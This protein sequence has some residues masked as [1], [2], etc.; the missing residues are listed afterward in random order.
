MP[1]LRLTTSAIVYSD[2]GEAVSP[3]LRHM[4]W[5]RATVV[6]NVDDPRSEMHTL[7][8][9]ASV[10]VFDGERAL[11]SDGT[12]EITLALTSETDV[13]EFRHTA[14]TSPGFRAA[15]DTSAVVGGTVTTTV[16]ANQ[17]LT[18]AISGGSFAAISAGDSLWVPG[19]EESVTS[20]FAVENRGFWVVMAAAAG[21]MTLR[22]SGSDFDGAS[23][24]VAVA[25]VDEFRAFAP[26]GVQVG[27]SLAVAAPFATVNQG[28]YV[29]NE[30]TD[31]YVLVRSDLSLAAE[32]VAAVDAGISIYTNSKRW[33][34]VESDCEVI[35][36][37]NGDAT[38]LNTIAPWSPED[39]GEWSKTG[40]TWSLEIENPTQATAHVTIMSVE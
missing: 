8:P 33:V 27:D 22:R 25:S 17:T 37:V 40:P 3:R 32:V 13:Y 38:S 24:V 6:L 35:A 21:S 5:M 29:V 4:D 36:H 30:V 12:T 9:G 18:M 10:V 20:P 7:A 14:G 23:E 1:N 15:R 34:R 28:T 39:P 16:N 31:E 2:S 19:A 11:T 26:T